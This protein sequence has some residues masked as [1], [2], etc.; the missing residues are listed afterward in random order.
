MNVRLQLSLFL[1]FVTLVLFQ[2]CSP[3][4]K[5]RAVATSFTQHE[6]LQPPVN[7]MAPFPA[8]NQ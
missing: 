4:N 1:S 3:S 2:N 8:S 6:S 5:P 7:P